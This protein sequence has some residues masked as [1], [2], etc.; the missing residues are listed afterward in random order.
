MKNLLAAALLTVLGLATTPKATAQA[1]PDFPS[2]QPAT[3]RNAAKPARNERGTAQLSRE[4]RRAQMTP[5]E[6]QQ[7]QQLQIMEA[8]TGNTSFARGDE[9]QLDKAHGAFTVRKFKQRPGTAKEVRGMSHPA[10]GMVMRG[11]PL[12]HNHNKKKFLLF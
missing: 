5:E 3:G 4:Q 10:G 2:A 9:R 12:V 8:R 1:A 6:A 11:K 7:D